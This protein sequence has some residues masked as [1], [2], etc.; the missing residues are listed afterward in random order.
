MKTKIFLALVLYIF[1]CGTV[2]SQIYTPVFPTKFGDN[3]NRIDVSGTLHFPRGTSPTLNSGKTDAGALFYKT[4][5]NYLYVW[6]GTTW[7]KMAKFADAGGG[8]GSPD[9]VNSVAVRNVA[10]LMAFKYYEFPS[11]KKNAVDAPMVYLAGYNIIGDGG[12]GPLVWV[13]TSTK[14]HNGGTI[15]NPT[16]HSGNG[17]WERPE[18]GYVNVLWFGATR[19]LTTIPSTDSRPAFVAAIAALKSYQLNNGA[20]GLTGVY[21]TQKLRVPYGNY[22]INDSIKVWNSIV[23]EGDDEIQ[24]PSNSTRLFFPQDK[25]GFI[26]ARRGDGT[27]ARNITVRNLY[28]SSAG[29]SSDTLMNGIRANCKVDLFNVSVENFGGHGIYL[30]TLDSGDCSNSKIRECLTYY[31]KLHGIYIESGESNNIVVSGCNSRTNGGSNFAENGALGNH[32]EFCHSAS[33][34]GRPGQQGW[35]SYG[36]Y[37]WVCIGALNVGVGAVNVNKVPG[38]TGSE[39]YWQ[40]FP[41]GTIDPGIVSAWNSSVTYKITSGYAVLNSASGSD[42]MNC[43]DEGGTAGI[44]LNLGSI[45]WNGD[46]ANGVARPWMTWQRMGGGFFKSTTGI[47]SESTTGDSSF[48]EFNGAY[49]LTF[50]KYIN[51]DE[52][53]LNIKYDTGAKLTYGFAGNTIGYHSFNIAGQYASPSPH[54]WSTIKPGMWTWSPAYGFSMAAMSNSGIKRNILADVAAPTSGEHTKNDICINLSDD[55]SILWWKC[56]VSGTP[57][58]WVAMSTGGGG[59]T[60]VGNYGNLQINRNGVFATPASDTLIYTTSGGFVVKNIL[61]GNALYLPNSTTSLGSVYMGGIKW[62]QSYSPGSSPNQAWG[63]NAGSLSTAT[64]NTSNISIGDGAGANFNSSGNIAIGYRALSLHTGVDPSQDLYNTAVGYNSMGLATG[65]R[66]NVAMGVNTLRDAANGSYSNVA[67]GKGTALG[68]TT[69]GANSIVGA[70]VASGGTFTGEWNAIVGADVLVPATTATGNSILGA[71]AMYDGTSAQE[72]TIA[73]YYGGTNIT[74]ATGNAFLGAKT[75]LAI[76]DGSYNVFLGYGSGAGI[77][78]TSISNRFSL[79]KNTALTAGNATMIGD[80]T[81][82]RIGINKAEDATLTYE[83]TVGG[84]LAVETIDSTG[85]GTAINML[86]QD[87]ATGLIKKAAVPSGGGSGDILNGGNT[88]G[89]TVTVGTNDANAFN[90]ETNNVTRVAIGSTGGT[91]IGNTSGGTG[92]VPLIIDAPS[93]QTANLLEIGKN[94]FSGGYTTFDASGN[95]VRIGSNAAGI[96]SSGSLVNLNTGFTSTGFTSGTGYGIL[97]ANGSGGSIANTA[98]IFDM[99]ANTVDSR[100]NLMLRNSNATTPGANLKIAKFD[101]TQQ[102]IFDGF[103]KMSIGSQAPTAMLHIQ[104]GTATA[105]TAPIKLTSGTNLTTP[106]DGAMEYNGTHLYYTIGSTRY[107]LDQ[108]AGGGAGTVNSGTQYRIAYYATTGTAVSEASAITASR[109][110]VSDANGVPTHATT[111]TT[112]LNYV[113]GVTSAIQTQLNA[114]GVGTVTNTGG[115]LTANS[116][117]LGAGTVDTKVVAGITTDGTSILNLGVNATT[118]GKVKMFGNTSGDVTILPQA[119]AGTASQ[120]TLPAFSGTASTL[121]GTETLTNKTIAA[122]SNTITGLTNTNLS[123][124]AGITNANLANSTI[125][126][127]S[128]GSNLANLT[129]TDATLTFSGT[130]TGATARTI[131]LNLSNANTWTANTIFQPTV[132]TG[133]NTTSGFQIA[134]NSLT[135]G[136]GVDIRSTT[137][138]SGTLLNV[139]SSSNAA[140]SNT[141]KL[142]DFSLTGSPSNTNQTTTTIRVRNETVSPGGGDKNI[143]LE[144][145]SLNGANNIAMY[146]SN[147]RVGIGTSSPTAGLHIAGGSA[148]TATIEGVLNLGSVGVVSGN[149]GFS[150]STSGSL[151]V[152]VPA[153]AGSSQTLT[154]PVVTG[155]VSAY[156]ETS[157]ASSSTP[158]PVGSSKDNYY[159]LTALAANATFSAPSGTILNHNTLLIRVKDNGTARTLS[160]NAI[161]RAGTDLALPTTTVIS[162]TDYYQFVYNS[163]DTKWDYIGQTKGF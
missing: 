3:M 99:N 80:L 160:W 141:Q 56:T 58:T 40:R 60:P 62:M 65:G 131:G 147:G 79:N 97:S 55:A 139:T 151:S 127:I 73:G 70:S 36:G 149:L 38:A 145:S 108:Q 155:T 143:A 8:G 142:A 94:G 161:Y 69:C 90:L 85:T 49:G 50:G 66:N 130:Y 115:N 114:K 126:G 134:A 107:Q 18:V 152:T 41:N 67:I 22:K 93:G 105:N 61:T 118:I 6:N 140:V 159:D 116:V 123:G 4:V 37:Q 153:V 113:S 15:F 9:S 5:D 27:G 71:Q 81:N 148:G 17:R 7:D 98:F 47:R 76:T 135:T 74:T 122:G 32:Y 34:G 157:T 121:A 88:T 163:A 31:N 75:G 106:E 39:N 137:L 63:I 110:L 48:V 51:G 129:A 14:V 120:F 128:L 35:V 146:V 24:W 102:F 95:I 138:S 100:V 124:T 112:E 46:L 20:S 2:F 19:S 78:N 156:S 45:A 119:V 29:L 136:S 42:F 43:Y 104:A 72:N 91:K 86:Y 117:V 82:K 23:I 89:A 54:G 96:S 33:A 59:G 87:P 68:C 12:E 25:A 125:S 26:F 162:K 144:L 16:G 13:D 154:L 53:A 158:A 101:N 109:A 92:V 28:L 77:A 1:L 132:T 52:A 133:S 84:K 21:S 11:L 111:T 150:G 44:V 30:T 83:L 103:G 64:T 57:G 10:D